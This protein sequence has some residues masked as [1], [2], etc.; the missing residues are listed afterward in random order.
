M[1]NEDA[2]GKAWF[3]K[4]KIANKNELDGM[5]DKAAYDKLVG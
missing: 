4:I 2:E 3:M 1:V 5:M